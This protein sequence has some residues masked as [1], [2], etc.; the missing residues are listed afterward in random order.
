[1]NTISTATTQ[2]RI[3]KQSPFIEAIKLAARMLAAK[4]IRDQRNKQLCVCLQY[5]GDN[6]DCPIHGKAPKAKGA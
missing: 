4:Q 5:I 1:M 3:E 6:G 2:T